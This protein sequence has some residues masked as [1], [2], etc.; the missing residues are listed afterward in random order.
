MSFFNTHISYISFQ[1]LEYDFVINKINFIM[2]INIAYFMKKIQD[3]C[4]NSTNVFDL[5][6]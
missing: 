3:F 4:I 5:S 2:L 1:P 6:Y